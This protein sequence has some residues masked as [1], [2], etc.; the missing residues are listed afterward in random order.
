MLGDGVGG[1]SNL[2]GP[3]AVIR[4]DREQRG[5]CRQVFDVGDGLGREQVPLERNAQERGES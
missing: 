2:F 1:S 5:Q 3:A 4:I